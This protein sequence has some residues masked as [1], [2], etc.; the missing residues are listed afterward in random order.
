MNGNTVDAITALSRPSPWIASL[1]K[2]AAR[3]APRS[4]SE[5]LAEEWMADWVQQ[6]GLGDRIRFVCGCYWA[7]M[8]IGHDHPLPA[9]AP[10]LLHSASQRTA[11]Q[12][13][14]RGSVYSHSRAAA[15]SATMMSEMNI[16][17]LIDVM[18]VL[19]VALIVSLPT[20]THAVK[21]ELPQG[22]STQAKQATV[23]DLDIDSDGTIAWNGTVLTGLQQLEDYFRAQAQQDPQS[24]IHLR[25][26]R[27]AKYDV[28][29]R[30]L[31]SA[32]RNRMANMAFA[33]TSEFAN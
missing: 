15:A 4:L 3:H 29:A 32:Q 9:P 12:R 22:V 1:L 27:R 10:A 25:P 20:M 5:R 11:G 17:P 14:P 13:P 8:V 23:I 26:D 24:E 21:L 7:A 18:L 16:T 31:A 6:R 30:V 19:L 2:G 28:V 33:N